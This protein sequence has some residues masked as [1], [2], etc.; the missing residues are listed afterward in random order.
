MPMTTIKSKGYTAI[1][2]V[3]V[4]LYMMSAMVYAHDAPDME[5]EGSIHI[6]MLFGEEAVPGGS[7]TLYRVGDVREDDGDYD[8]VLTEDFKASGENLENIQ[9]EG[10]AA[11]LQAYAE[12]QK[13]TGLTRTV[14]RDG[15][16]AFDNL[17]LG[18]YLLVQNQA[19][20]G[21]LEAAPFL[22][23]VPMLEDGV[24]IYEV[25]ANT[26]VE[27]EKIPETPPQTEPPQ[28]EP[29]QTE[30]PQTEPSE[31]EPPA[32]EPPESRPPESETTETEMPK[33]PV[34]PQLP[35]TGQLNWPIPIMV[36]IGLILFMSGW[37]L[38]RGGKK[39]NYEK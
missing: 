13:L 18:L 30:P 14:S 11:K 39:G 37:L 32:S 9:T 22:V 27:L 26:K 8:F 16:I 15:T 21:Y 17:K 23:S 12:N 5:R 4:L 6:T 3:A 31:T 38:Y 28:T 29:P 20:D 10:L 33:N 35:Q 2:I 24:Y 25:I 19:A 1:L 34:T 7:L 36:V